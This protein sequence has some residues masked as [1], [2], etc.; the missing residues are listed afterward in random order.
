MILFILAISAGLL[1]AGIEV[2]Y[3]MVHPWTWVHWMVA[4]PLNVALAILIFLLV[5]RA[6]AFVQ[7]MVLFG[8]SA[9][10][11]RI[12]S[13]VVML[14]EPVTKGTITALALLVIAAVVRG[15]WK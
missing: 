6:E 3:R 13:V 2:S 15:I 11:A 10:L 5:T 9:L 7:A 4:A 8:L 14:H 1:A 12:V